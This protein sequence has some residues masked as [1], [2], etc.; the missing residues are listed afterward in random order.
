[1]SQGNDLIS[2]EAAIELVKNLYLDDDS[3]VECPDECNSMIDA[4]IEALRE[5]PAEPRW[6]PCSEMMPE[7]ETYVLICNS[8]GNIAIS[9]GAYSTE[10]SD[11]IW[12]TSGWLFGEVIAWMPLPEPWRGEE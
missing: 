2:R 5:L 1:M 6:I 9:R 10:A 8:T 3:T 4:C 11:W 7:E 12:Y